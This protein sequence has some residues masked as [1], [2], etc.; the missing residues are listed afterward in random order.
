MRHLALVIMLIASIINISAHESDT[1]VSLVT[2]YPGHDIYELEGHT[3]IRVRTDDMHD[4]AIHW[5]LFDFDAPNFVYRFVKGETDYMCGMMPWRYFVESYRMHGRRVEEQV[6]EL[7]PIQKRHI[8][9]I[10]Q[11]NLLPHNRV[12]RY[13]YVKD[14][15]ATRPMQ[16]IRAATG[17]S[18]HT[19]PCLFDTW[20]APTS[21]RDVMRFYHK[22]Y[23]WYQFG[24]DLALGAGIDYPLKPSEYAFAPLLLEQMIN[25]ATIHGRHIARPARTVV[26][27]PADN[28]VQEPT[29]WYLT[30]ITVCWCIFI[31]LLWA[32]IRDRRRRQ[33]TKW[34]DSLYFGIIGLTGLLLTFLMFVSVHEATSPNYLYLWLNPSGL[35]PVVF[36][37]LKN[38][39]KVVFCYQIINFAAIFIGLACWWWL[40]Q[41]TNAAFLPLV[42]SD[43]LR[44]SN[45]ISLTYKTLRKN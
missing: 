20:S 4:V 45:Y 30:P 5:G 31:L 44:S 42:L 7:D 35:I 37:W 2:C 40:P 10:L 27:F 1:L 12:Y 38:G 11:Q 25:G 28:A 33:V 24:I 18:L 9:D 32:T 17:D 6:L 29:P 19:G 15:C 26:D 21:F 23:P 41:S 36:I 3:A 13:N 16:I 8:I 43:L 39:N 14:N 34:V 22:N